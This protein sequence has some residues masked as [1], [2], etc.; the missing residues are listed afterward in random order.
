MT[1]VIRGRVV[2]VEPR[3]SLRDFNRAAERVYWRHLLYE[4]RGNIIQ[5]TNRSGIQSRST[6]YHR[7][8][9]FGLNP[10]EFRC[11]WQDQ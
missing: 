4:T 3:M 5:T 10:S 1:I 11:T 9:D 7:L 2:V 6:V 8:R